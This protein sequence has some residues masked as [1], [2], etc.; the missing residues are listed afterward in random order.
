[1][2]KSRAKVL[3]LFFPIAGFVDYVSTIASSP[4]FSSVSHYYCDFVVIEE[5]MSTDIVK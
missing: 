5:K 1:M 4:I 3:A 2:K